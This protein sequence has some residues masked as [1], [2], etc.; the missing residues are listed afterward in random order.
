[1][2]ASSYSNRENNKV[3]INTALGIILGDTLRAQVLPDFVKA[4]GADVLGGMRCN[5]DYA[6]L[7]ILDP[8]K[9]YVAWSDRYAWIHFKQAD[10]DV[11]VLEATDELV[12]DI[13]IPLSQDLLD[14]LGVKHIL[15]VDL[16]AD[17]KMPPGF[18]LVG[19]VEQCRLL[20]RD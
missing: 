2:I 14:R 12:Y 1:M 11:P 8:G 20:E 17:Q 9:K 19:T 18:L 4:A 3:Q 15:E 10:V 6:M 7:Q 5:P 13:K 16:P